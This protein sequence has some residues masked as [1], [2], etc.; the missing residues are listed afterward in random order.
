MS[1]SIGFAFSHR[2]DPNRTPAPTEVTSRNRSCIQPET[3]SQSYRSP[4]CDCEKFFAD[5]N[6]LISISRWNKSAA[7]FVSQIK[8]EHVGARFRGSLVFKGDRNDRSSTKTRCSRPCDAGCRQ[9]YDWRA[10]F[11]S[12]LPTACADHQTRRS[13]GRAGAPNKQGDRAAFPDCAF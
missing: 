11:A 1:R 6:D 3:P 13:V 2:L 10:R 8:G 12:R 7:R 4:A 5:Q 9:H